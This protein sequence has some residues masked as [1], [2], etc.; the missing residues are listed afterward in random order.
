[1]EESLDDRIDVVDGGPGR[2]ARA[3]RRR[4]R[5]RCRQG[6]VFRRRRRRQARVVEIAAAVPLGRRSA[7]DRVPAV[8]QQPAGG[9]PRALPRRL[10]RRSKGQGRP[11][12]ADRRDAGQGR[13]ARAQLRRGAGRALPAGRVHPRVRRQGVGGLRGDGP[14]RQRREVRRAARRSDP[15]PALRRGRLHAQPPGRARL[16]H[17][18]PARKRRRG[19]GQA[20]DGDRALRRPPLRPP[21]AGDGRRAERDHA[22][23][24]QAVLRPA[25][26]ARSPGRRRGRRLRRRLRRRVHAPVRVARPQ[27]RAA[28]AA[29]APAPPRRHRDPDR[30]E[31]RARQ[32]HLD[33]A[34]AADHARQ[35][36]LLSADRRAVVP[37]R[38]PHLQRRADESP[39]RQPRPELRR[40]RV[41]RELHPGRLVDVPAAQHPAPRAALRD[42]AASGAAGEQPVRA[43][44]GA[45]RDRQADPRRASPR[46]DS[47]RPRRS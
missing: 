38:A 21:V 33:R 20:G 9:D 31:G 16:R 19:P 11:G 2:A 46:P 45:V 23:R 22:R 1:M 43:A 34:P 32:R 28:A 36:R 7:E 10:R 27:G 40:L 41:H 18:D 6:A 3:C 15:E 39:A 44:R 30:R 5:R 8:A 37:G 24:R 13:Y 17:Q 42:L 35:Q 29:A 14:P 12:R 25:L 26:H 47:R 4:R